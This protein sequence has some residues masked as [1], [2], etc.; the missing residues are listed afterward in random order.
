[1]A[2]APITFPLSTAPGVNSTESG[3]RLINAYAEPM[4][5]GARNAWRWTRVAGL[6]LATTVGIADFRGAIIV[7]AVLYVINGAKA[8]TVTKAGT[9]YTVNE[10]TGSVGGDGPVIMARNMRAGTQI[11][12]VHSGGMSKI[13]AGVVADFSDVDLPATNSVDFMDGFFFVTS[14]DG[15]VFASG[16]NDITFNSLDYAT[17][18]SSPD[19]LVRAVSFGRDLLLMGTVTT[20]FWGNTGNATGFPFSRGPVVPVGLK[21]PYAIAGMGFGFP[22]PLAWVANDNTV[23]RLNGYSPEVISIPALERLIENVA[24]VADLQAMAYVTAGR[25]FWVLSGPGWTWAF[26]MRTGNWHERQ[27]YGSDRW[28]VHLGVNAFGEWVTFDRD[29]AKMFKIDKGY[30]YEDSDP[31]IWEV[32]STQ[33]HRFPGRLRVNRASFNFETGVGNDT[34]ISPIE[35]DPQVSISWSNDGGRTFGNSLLRSLGTQGEQR[36]IDIWNCGLTGPNGRQ[37]RLQCSDPVEVSMIGGAQ[38]FEGVQP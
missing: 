4:N 13:E 12:I 27:S 6:R 33:D 28:R 16:L 30:R 26:D 2:G 24:D 1:M 19:G 18:E 31:L 9:V 23:R 10:L 35:T 37:W 36:S 15:R 5:Q 3:G 38:D 25:A 22:E 14:A 29:T 8:Y 20:E 17:A 34:G 7:G 21:G 11:L 32:R